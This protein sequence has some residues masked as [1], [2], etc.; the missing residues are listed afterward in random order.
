M[1]QRPSAKYDFF[2][3]YSA[4]DKYHTTKPKSRQKRLTRNFDNAKGV[5]STLC[6]FFKRSNRKVINV[7]KFTQHFPNYLANMVNLK[8]CLQRILLWL[9]ERLLIRLLWRAAKHNKTLCNC[10]NVFWHECTLCFSNMS[11]GCVQ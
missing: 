10:L 8:Q 6:L 7:Q 9:A 1:E 2:I 3:S 11:R 5:S 4:L